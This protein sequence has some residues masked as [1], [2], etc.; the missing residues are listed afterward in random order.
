MKRTAILILSILILI[1]LVFAARRPGG[2]TANYI[3]ASTVGQNDVDQ[4]GPPWYK[5]EWSYRLP[6]GISSNSD[7]PIDYYQVLI[8][9]KSSN[10][11]FSHAK[12]DGSDIRF[13]NSSGT[14]PLPYWIES[15][16][17][18]SQHAYIWVLVSLLPK[19]FD[20]TIYLYYHNP[21]AASASN[22][23]A[24]FIDF[25]D[26]DW[27][28]FPGSGCTQ[29]STAQQM[30]ISE[31]DQNLSNIIRDKNPIGILSSNWITLTGT[32]SVSSGMLNLPAGT[33]IKSKNTFGPNQ[34]VGY[35]A[36][37][38]L[39]NGYEWG[40]FIDGNNGPRTMIGDLPT[41]RY[42]LFLIDYPGDNSSKLGST[43]W[44]DIAH[45]FEVRWKNGQSVADIDHGAS[46]ITNTSQ[47][48]S[49][50]LPVTFYS[51]SGSGATLQV[52]WVYVRQYR[53]PEP[54]PN[55]DI[56]RE[57]GLVALNV[58]VSDLPDPLPRDH[59][60]SY[61]IT[62]TNTS[63][64]DAPGV[65]L[66]DT[67]PVGASF[68]RTSPLIGCTHSAGKVVC[69][70][71][72]VQAF[73]TGKVTIV[74]SPIIDNGVI[75]NTVTTGSPSYELDLSNNSRQVSTLVDSTPPSVNW[76][77]PVKN[78][79]KFTTS[80]GFISLEAS[81]TDNDQVASVEF[82]YW[83]HIN[84]TWKSIGIDGTYP[85]QI[86]FNS[87][88]LVANQE[89]QVFVQASDRAG[90]ISSIY[91]LPYPVI[92]ITRYLRLETFLPLAIK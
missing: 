35:R 63:S 66:T 26:D 51:Y 16:D 10:F 73:S 18:A 47:V 50:S 39:G 45:T 91:T 46:N 72:T 78:G 48:P 6:I 89:Y 59:E 1:I 24:T 88:V 85:Y 57:Q 17:K 64:I 62:V 61:P 71:N 42:G 38:G 55:I 34:A 11:D 7:N 52:D 8:E 12:D 20:T 86:D 32:T 5:K 49:G 69:N 15:W 28:G 58:D 21:A 75:T 31:Y 90:N 80:G 25:F 68:I 83:D 2:A 27:C 60:L 4:V 92:Y 44:H 77:L 23:P 65:V 13:T 84:N 40:G 36:T 3:P 56:N 43:N 9:L 76:E 29:N 33:G 79:Q 74:V 37:F 81:A 30:V 82:I 19:P 41:D 87:D 14:V 54:A 53:Y 70:L 67:L 22:G